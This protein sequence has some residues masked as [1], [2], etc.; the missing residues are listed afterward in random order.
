MSTPV[1]HSVLVV[2]DEEI[3]R[4]ILRQLLEGSGYDVFTASS[5]ENAVQIFSEKEISITLTDIKMS[6]KERHSSYS[7]KIDQIGRSRGAIVIKS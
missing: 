2:E 5:A 6:G 3:M 7:T 4:T 1:K